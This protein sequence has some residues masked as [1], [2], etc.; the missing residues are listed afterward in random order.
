[1]SACVLEPHCSLDCQWELPSSVGGNS[2]LRQ[3]DRKWFS[4][5]LHAQQIISR[6]TQ[7]EPLSTPMKMRALKVVGA[8]RS[9]AGSPSFQVASQLAVGELK[10]LQLC[11]LSPN[12]VACWTCPVLVCR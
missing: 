8:L 4:C 12:V 10:T 2:S 7:L 3:G 11:H 1:M 6:Y 9:F 5:V